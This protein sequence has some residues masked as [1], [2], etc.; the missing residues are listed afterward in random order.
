MDW[1]YVEADDDNVRFIRFRALCK[2]ESTTIIL[3]TF[4]GL[5]INSSKPFP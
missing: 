1:T 3:E 5:F 2:L 4:N